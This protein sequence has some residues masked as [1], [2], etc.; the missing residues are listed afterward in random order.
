MLSLEK[1]GQS[2]LGREIRVKT[3]HYN[4]ASKLNSSKKG[5]NKR[6]KFQKQTKSPSSPAKKPSVEVSASPN[7]ARNK[8]RKVQ[9][10]QAKADF[11]GEM[12]SKKKLTKKSLK[13]RIKSNKLNKQKKNFAEILSK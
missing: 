1:N 6:N 2:F 4:P 7:K 11:K 10:E 3:Y 12:S 5:G 8:S 13:S 9:P